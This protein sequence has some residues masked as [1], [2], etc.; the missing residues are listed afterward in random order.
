MTETERKG[1]LA[2]QET[3]VGVREMEEWDD[4]SSSGESHHSS[5]MD[6]SDDSH[7]EGQLFLEVG[8]IEPPLIS[9]HILVPPSDSMVVLCTCGISTA[10][11]HNY[12]EFLY[13]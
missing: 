8:T 10:C 5:D 7:T 9:C 3:F 6:L 1:D 4:S 11:P 12:K 2:S 13:I